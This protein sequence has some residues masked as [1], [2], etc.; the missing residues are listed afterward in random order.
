MEFRDFWLPKMIHCEWRRQNQT[1]RTRVIRVLCCVVA[2]HSS[3]RII[4]THHLNTRS[5][6]YFKIIM[7]PAQTLR[8]SSK[9]AGSSGLRA[10][11]HFWT[12]NNVA[13]FSVSDLWRTG[14][15]LFSN[16]FKS[17][18]FKYVCL[19]LYLSVWPDLLPQLASLLR[20]LPFLQVHTEGFDVFESIRTSFPGK[21]SGTL[22][23]ASITGNFTGGYRQKVSTV[24]QKIRLCL[25]DEGFRVSMRDYT[26]VYLSSAVV[27]LNLDV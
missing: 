13:V 18:L 17:R 20:V 7:L 19:L 22:W 15:R 2:R 12:S 16:C 4:I 6:M 14:W 5:F 10:L 11:P 1:K 9:R 23:V 25:F 27:I 21:E 3:R 24:A 8:G 26:P